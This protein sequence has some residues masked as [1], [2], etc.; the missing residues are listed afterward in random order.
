M[1]RRFVV[2]GQKATASDEFLLDDVPGTSGRL[3]I[4]LRCLRAALL[5][6]HGLRADVI[7]YLVLLGGPRAPRVMRVDGARV[8]FLR[9]DE[10]ALA[11]LAK[12]V[13]ASRADEDQPAAMFVEIKPGIALARGGIE[14]VLADAPS[15]TVIVLEEGAADIREATFFASDAKDNRAKIENDMLIIIGDHHG[16]P[17]N[18]KEIAGQRVSIGPVSIHADDVVA[19]VTNEIDRRSA[20][21]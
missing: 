16:L 20:M 12:K 6:S 15:S 7:V 17:E 9:P 21:R 2:I 19:V 8:Q 14:V 18:V 1:R 10:R 5:S 3:D 4:L 11:V 13:L